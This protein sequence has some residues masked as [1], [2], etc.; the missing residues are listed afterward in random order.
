M[1]RAGHVARIRGMRNAYK[2]FIGKSDRRGYLENPSVDK[3]IMLE[4]ILK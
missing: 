2:V 4:W 1:R 3:R